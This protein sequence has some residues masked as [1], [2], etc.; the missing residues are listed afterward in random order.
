M[1]T[2]PRPTPERQLEFLQRI[3]SLFEDGNFV[4]TYKYALLMSLAELAVERGTDDGSPL[5]LDLFQIGEKFAE[6]YWPQTVPYSSGVVGASVE[7]LAQN[8][9]AQAAVINKLLRLRQSGVNSACQRTPVFKKI[10]ELIL[11]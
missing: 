11:T 10:A 7:I 4:A 9:G 1:T 5:D 6:L 2:W 3:Q 8:R